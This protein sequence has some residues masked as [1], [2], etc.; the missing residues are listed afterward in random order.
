MHCIL[1]PEEMIKPHAHHILFQNGLGERQKELVRIGQDILREYGIDPILAHEN[2]IWAP[3]YAKGQHAEVVVKEIVE[4]LEEMAEFGMDKE[5]IINYLQ[6]MGR[7]A[8]GR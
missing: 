7:I 8:S 1:N 6:K 4:T 2:I 5:D 3:M